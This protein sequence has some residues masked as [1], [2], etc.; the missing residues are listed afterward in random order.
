MQR[1][2]AAI[3]ILLG[4]TDPARADPG[5]NACVACH[6]R[7][8]LPISLGHSF[9][10]WRGSAHGR[11]GVGCEKCHGGDA[12]ASDAAAA[13]K[14]VLPAADAESLVNPRH[15]AT[16]CGGCHERERD[17]YV[18]TVHAQE[19]KTH[20][21]GATCSTC[22]GAMATSLPSPSELAARCAAC[23]KKPLEA[24]AALAVLATTKAQLRRTQQ[25]IEATRTANATWYATGIERFHGLERQYSTIQVDWHHF[26]M[27]QVLKESRDV[28]KLAKPL[29]E[30]AGLMAQRPAE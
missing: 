8:V 19:V 13:H 22:H 21:R 9:A 5:A 20:G 12:S 16:T 23:H 10:D 29:A 30:E 3:A 24:E 26:K 4:L 15:L 14:S 11:G 6:E 1:T 2:L 27:T 25:A 18:D 28:Y 17:A 7:E